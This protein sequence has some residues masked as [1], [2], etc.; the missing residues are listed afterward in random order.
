MSFKDM[1]RIGL[2]F[3][4]NKDIGFFSKIF[5]NSEQNIILISFIDFIAKMDII[6]FFASNHIQIDSDMLIKESLTKTIPEI[7]CGQNSYLLK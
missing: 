4:S 5:S 6:D 7:V 3:Q 2:F 1:A